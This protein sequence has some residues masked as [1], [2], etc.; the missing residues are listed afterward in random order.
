MILIV[1]QELELVNLRQLTNESVDSYAN[2]FNQLATR[3]NLQDAI[4]KK[5]MFIAGLNPAL[6]PFITINNPANI[7]AAIEAAR[8]AETGFNIGIQ[9][10][11]TTVQ[12]TY[13]TPS[14][15]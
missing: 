8:T 9:K 13:T 1:E 11:S 10:L 4:Q 3:V 6:A 7:A 12:E 15:S 5:R 2:R 14:V